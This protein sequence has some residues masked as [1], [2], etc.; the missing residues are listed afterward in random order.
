MSRTSWIILGVVLGVVAVVTLVFAIRLAVRLVSMRRLLAGMGA[1]GKFVF[2]GALAYTI[3]P[4][5]LLPDP[6][7]LDD[8]GV[9]T[10]AL[11]Y[12]T[13]LA[14]KRE[15]LAGA[16]PHMRKVAAIQARRHPTTRP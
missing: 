7:Y 3:F 15:T 10:A 1:S 12:L 14:R 6:I 4:I 8:I 2:W 13:R 11:V 16:V 9:L 5:D